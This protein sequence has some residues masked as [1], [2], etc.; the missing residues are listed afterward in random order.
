MSGGGYFLAIAGAELYSMWFGRL[1]AIGNRAC[2]PARRRNC[3]DRR[4]GSVD[5]HCRT[6][7]YHRCPSASRDLAPVK[8]AIRAGHIGRSHARFAERAQIQESL[9]EVTEG[10]R[11]SPQIETRGVARVFRQHDGARALAKRSVGWRGQ[12]APTVEEL[13]GF[14]T[15]RYAGRRTSGRAP[16][17]RP[18]KVRAGL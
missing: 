8:S 17:G 14:A 4:L 7:A 3:G 12:A 15:T 13:V 18:V 11:R 5:S 1:Q 2:R 9:D 10:C 6:F 16:P